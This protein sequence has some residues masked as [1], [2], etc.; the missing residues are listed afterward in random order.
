[1][2]QN[3]II[4]SYKR[5]SSFYDLTFGQVFRP[6]QKAIIKKMDCI[7]SDNVLE[8]G[9]GTGSS[10]QYYPK[11]TKVVGIDIS[12]DMLEVAKKRIVKDKIHNK[13]ILLMNGER[14]SF[15][16]NSFD[17]V[18]GMYVVSVTQ[19]PQVLVEEMKRVCKNDGDIYIVNHFS[20]EQ[21][22][23]F[24]KM[25]EKGL[26]PIS[27]ILCWKPYFPF[28]EFNAYANLDVL[29]MSKVNLFNYWNIIHAS[30]NK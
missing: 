4:K 14:L 12:P 6:G 8:I 7:D 11:E 22:N 2:D 16:D 19:N 21:D 5:V 23:L 17:K 27:K 29:E 18:V 1:M 3:S 24:V 25:F 9:I 20:T 15:P 13:H 26:M 28:D 10:L 30:N